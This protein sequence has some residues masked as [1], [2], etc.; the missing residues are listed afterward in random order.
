MDPGDTR[1]LLTR[2][3]GGSW[4]GGEQLVEYLDLGVRSMRGFEAELRARA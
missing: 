4:T 1:L 2:V 3:P